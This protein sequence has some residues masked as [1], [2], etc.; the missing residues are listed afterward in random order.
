MIIY[1]SGRLSV[2][3]MLFISTISYAGH[4]YLLDQS[5]VFSDDAREVN[6][7]F[8]DVNN[9]G[10]IDMVIGKH[11]D[12]KIGRTAAFQQT[13]TG[14]DAGTEIYQG[15]N[16]NVNPLVGYINGS[17][18][19]VVN[20]HDQ[21][22]RG[23]NLQF[24]K[25]DSDFVI[26]SSY[27][28]P[29]NHPYFSDQVLI[30]ETVYFNTRGKLG[31]AEWNDLSPGFTSTELADNGEGN[32]LT[33]TEAEDLTG[34][35][36]QDVIYWTYD[37]NARGLSVLTN[38]TE[39]VIEYGYTVYFTTGQFDAGTD[40]HEILYANNNLDSLT[41]V[42]YNTDTNMF[43]SE[44]VL[45]QQEETVYTVTAIDI[46]GDGTDEV[47]LATPSGEIF[48]FNL[49]TQQLKTV[50]TTD[51]YWY[52]SVVAD[53]GNGSRAVFVG[54]ENGDISVVSFGQDNAVID[55][56]VGNAYLQGESVDIN[57]TFDAQAAMLDVQVRRTSEETWTT[58]MTVSSL[59]G[60]CQ[61]TGLLEGEY[62]LRLADAGDNHIVYGQIGTFYVY[63]CSQT[64]AGDLSG[65]CYVDFE[66]FSLFA[67]NYTDLSDLAQ[68]ALDWLCCG[69]P[70]DETCN[71]L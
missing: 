68:I 15:G 65:D 2:F 20:K 55:D 36:V 3:I 42:R 53:W 70:Y 43:V 28:V 8:G 40:I 63:I 59:A 24:L 25:F 22:N 26:E 39:V 7:C 19:L 46:D 12:H 48:E 34:D 14:W 54:S 62:D 30:G 23:G 71:N 6:I 5:P 4:Q 27:S 64:L 16:G 58:M 31:K 32:K 60:A 56:I 61:L 52:D 51:V 1:N 69:N 18:R 49:V 9:D 45:T 47:L 17:N 10:V 67:S 50:L 66:D 38:N 44:V 41:L 29:L 11:Q 57:W 37:G 35:G 33:T 21:D 13:Q